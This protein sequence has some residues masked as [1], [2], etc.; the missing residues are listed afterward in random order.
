MTRLCKSFPG[1]LL[2]LPVP[3]LS[4]REIPV[5]GQAVIEGVLMRGPA[6][7]ALAV[8]PPEGGIWTKWWEARPWNASMPWSL[9]VLRGVA[10]M[11]EMLVTGF[12]AISLSAQV[13]LGEEEKIGPLELAATFAVAIVGVVGLFIILPVW[14]SDIGIRFLKVDPFW[15][16]IIEGLARAMIFIAYIAVIGLWKDI[17][18]VFAYH[19]AEHKTINAWESGASLDTA[20]VS[21]FSRIHGRCG[22]SFLL[23]VIVVSVIVFAAAGHG[24]IIWRILS[25]VVLLPLVIGI[26]YE[27]I[28]WCAKNRTAGRALMAPALWLQYLT[29][30][31]PD[32]D[33]LEV[34]ISALNLALEDKAGP[35]AGDGG[36]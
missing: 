1:L 19:G 14:V 20:T 32:L 24:S 26:S 27:I 35:I 2:G 17:S 30:R 34:A 6:R 12:R 16:L 5:G 15:L 22:T 31:E 21:G 28:R 25:R 4:A 29:T 3:L 10:T 9:P 23:V 7:W 13:A 33:Q 11:G 8:R 18:R 36:E